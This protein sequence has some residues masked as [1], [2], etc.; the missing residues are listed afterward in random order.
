MPVIAGDAPP[1]NSHCVP[2]HKVQAITGIC[3]CSGCP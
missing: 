3:P 1:S 2:A